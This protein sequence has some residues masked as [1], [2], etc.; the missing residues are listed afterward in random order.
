MS[1]THWLVST[2]HFYG[3]FPFIINGYVA[4]V[5]VTSL[6]MEYSLCI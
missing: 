3:I 2:L 5:K 1:K 4:V 6:G